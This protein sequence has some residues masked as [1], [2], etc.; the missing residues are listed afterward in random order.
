MTYPLFSDHRLVQTAVVGDAHSDHPVIL[1]MDAAEL[2]AWRKRHPHYTYWC[3]YELGGC[4]GKLS[5]RLYHDK[6]CHFAHQP[7]GPTCGRAA[8]G[9]S[10]ADHLFIK[11]GLR[12]LLGKHKQRGTVKT[13]DLGSGPGGAVDL[14]LP[15]AR[16]R[17][18]FQLSRLDY[19]GWRAANLALADD[20]DEVDWLFGTDD[21]LT[22]ELLARHGYSLRFR[23]ETVGGE[24]HVHIARQHREEPTVQWS[25]LEDCHITSTGLLTPPAEPV[26]TSPPRPK[27]FAF[28]IA[29]SVVFVLDPDAPVPDDSPFTTEGRRLVM[30]DVKPVDSPIVRAVLSLPDDTELPP[31]EHVYR[32]PDHA[33]VLVHE[34]SGGWAVHLDRFLRLNAMEAARTGL[35]T[36]PTEPRDSQPPSP[37]Q[38]S[39]P[40]QPVRTMPARTRPKA[41]KSQ[42]GTREAKA[43]PFKPAETKPAAAANR[44]QVRK[45]PVKLSRGQAIVRVR[46]ILRAAAPQGR[47]VD[48]LSLVTQLGAGAPL[49][50]MSE[51]DRIAFLAEVDSPLWESKP[52]LS[53]LLCENGGLLPCLPAVLAKLGVRGADGLSASSP[54]LREWVA[55]ER[56]RATAV[57]T[58]PPRA[59]PPRVELPV[60]RPASTL[61][62]KQQKE[63][64][65]LR[66]RLQTR[67]EQPKP[68]MSS[69]EERRMVRQALERLEEMIPRLTPGASVSKSARMATK[70]ARLWLQYAMPGASIPREPTKKESQALATGYSRVLATLVEAEA[71]AAAVQPDP[72]EE[73]KRLLVAVA[74]R[75]RTLTSAELE[76]TRAVHSRRQPDLLMELDRRATDDAP[77]LSSLVTDHTG[78]P[79]PYFRNILQ[80]AGYEAPRTDEALTLVWRREQ[81]R[82]HAAHAVPPRPLPERL[83]PKAGAAAQSTP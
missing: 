77:L 71:A 81:E 65:A 11:R 79:L 48:W 25:P 6:V 30:A 34:G 50:G 26:H 39:V 69:P 58:K 80:A 43:A 27:P 37:S 31:A 4:G 61:T 16:C 63:V 10:S 33:R 74:S 28:P 75:G 67:P 83:V 14:H 52:V 55:R 54:A 1:P 53:A 19:R 57:Y 15:A 23:L 44:S 49:A 46:D 82:A 18:R 51:H 29:G 7:G 41:E 17:L 73:I 70:R 78:A 72:L 3:G 21:P 5:D 64:A 8:T 42:P 47:V 76:A 12:N 40:A 36:A 9:E 2:D 60:A 66:R 62:K 35:A 32:A 22:K 59:V 20:V 38:A 45:K 68:L 24:R 13:R 56:E